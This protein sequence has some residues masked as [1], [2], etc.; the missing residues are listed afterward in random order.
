MT[1]TKHPFEA[2]SEQIHADPEYAWG[3]LCNLAVPIMDAANV[4]H[5]AAN[6]AAALIM[7]QMFG[8][9]ITTHERFVG[10]KSSHQ[11]YHEA[12]VEC[13]RLEDITLGHP[14]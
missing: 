4:S 13:E 1:D 3:W 6:Q 11:L 7:A 2:L 5:V 14:S 12:R 8:Y 9:D 10:G